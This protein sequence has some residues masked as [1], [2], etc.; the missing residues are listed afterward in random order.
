MRLN[1]DANLPPPPCETPEQE[2]EPAP[3]RTLTPNE[4]E[5]FRATAKRLCA[6]RER[7]GI[8][9]GLLLHGV[10]VSV[11]AMS[12]VAI[13]ELGNL[14]QQDGMNKSLLLRLFTHYFSSLTPEERQT[15][16]ER[17]NQR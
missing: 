17:L 14:T 16:Y 12:T 1:Y 9:M 2:P 3:R 15:I 7:D 6:E 11:I 10:S 5:L 13:D 4:V 8:W